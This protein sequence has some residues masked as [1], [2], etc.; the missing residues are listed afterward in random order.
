MEKT[1]LCLGRWKVSSG[2]GA[3]LLWGEAAFLV[4]GCA[5]PCQLDIDMY[6]SAYVCVSGTGNCI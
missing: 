4:G 6:M 1:L 3:S 5:W 2:Y